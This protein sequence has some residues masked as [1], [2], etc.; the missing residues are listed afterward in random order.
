M[1]ILSKIKLCEN[2]EDFL[3]KLNTFLD[4]KSKGYSCLVN[5]NISLNC[6]KDNFYFKT[7]Q[8][9]AFNVCD[10]ISIEIINNLTKKRKIKSYP[11][12]DIFRE[13]TRNNF[14][15]Q[16]F[17]G[18]ENEILLKSLRNNLKNPNF[19]MKDFYCPPFLNVEDFD[20]L[21]ISKLINQNKPDII[22]IGL[23]APKQEIFMS[24]LLPHIDSGLMIGV[25]AAFNFYSG[26]KNHKRAPLFF[27]RYKIEW[28]FRLI[29][30]PK[31][32]FPRVFRNIIYLPIILIKEFR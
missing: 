7:I 22:W 12:P 21:K 31:K 10:A 3:L 32:T 13:I 24:K 28:L 6:Y 26:Y 19:K 5:P 1:S 16:F 25:G 11:G 14:Y 20:Y 29:N 23:G 9:A 30:E 15:S 2:K 8:S 17:I 27:R 18:G 4:N